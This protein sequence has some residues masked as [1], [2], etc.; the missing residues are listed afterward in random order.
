MRC[1]LNLRSR[2]ATT[3]ID[4]TRNIARIVAAIAS[5]GAVIDVTSTGE[6]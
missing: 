4:D 3:G 2:A 6:S 5:C 1:T